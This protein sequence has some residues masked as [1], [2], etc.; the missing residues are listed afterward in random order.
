MKTVEIIGYPVGMSIS[1]SF[2]ILN[3]RY[4]QKLNSTKNK[5]PTVE[6]TIEEAKCKHVVNPMVRKS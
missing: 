5:Q 1:N 2:F 4:I 3:F 6:T